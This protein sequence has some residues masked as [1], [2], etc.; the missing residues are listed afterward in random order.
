[1]NQ[2]LVDGLVQLCKAKPVGNDAVRWLGEWLVAN[3]PARPVGG[4]A[5]T[6][7]TSSKAIASSA[8]SAPSSVIVTAPSLPVANFP[9]GMTRAQYVNGGAAVVVPEAPTRTIV[10]VLGGPGA[11][12]GTQCERIV[13][14]F[15]FTHLSTGDLLRAEVASGSERG[16]TFKSIMDKGDLV[17]LTDILGMVQE[18]MNKSGSNKFLLDGYP[19]ALEQAF[20]FEQQ[21]GPATFCLAID[22]SD[23]T[24]KARLLARGASSGR[25]DDNEETIVKRIQTFHEQSEAAIDFYSRLGKLKRI[26]SELPKEEVYAQVRK[27]FQPCVV[28]VAGKPGSGKGTQC[29]RVAAR[30]GY[31]HIS[32]SDLF[33]RL[34]YY[35]NPLI[36][37]R[38]PCLVVAIVL[39]KSS[40]KLIET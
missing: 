6:S 22:C 23:E 34:F 12:K 24:M 2:V 39:L 20:A 9:G 13:E 17:P 26:N 10:F 33:Q 8:P 38:L 15:G 29:K 28:F 27:A 14:E 21:I 19:R 32:A 7:T 31:Q 5:T 35:F 3:N 25:S 11:G 16:L 4:G 40:L 36:F 1:M 37:F 30:Y 18:T